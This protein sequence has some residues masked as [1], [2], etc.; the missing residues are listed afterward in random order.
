MDLTNTSAIVTG[1]ATPPGGRTAENPL[2]AKFAGPR[3]RRLRTAGTS[4]PRGVLSGSYV[5][6]NPVLY[7]RS[8]LRG[9]GA[10]RPSE[11]APTKLS[12]ARRHSLRSLPERREGLFQAYVMV[13]ISAKLALERC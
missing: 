1:G 10:M 6:T 4:I 5:P 12:K 11:N 9:T 8:P 13:R 3:S 2:Y 7:I